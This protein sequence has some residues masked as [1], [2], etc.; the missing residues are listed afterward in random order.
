MNFLTEYDYHISYAKGSSNKADLLSQCT[1]F[2]DR[3]N[4]N[5]DQIMLLKSKF[6]SIETL[7]GSRVNKESLKPYDVEEYITKLTS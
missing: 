3:S 1:D 7:S 5:E 2:D 6:S 4:D